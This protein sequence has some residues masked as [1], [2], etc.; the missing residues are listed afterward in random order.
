MICCK[1]AISLLSIGFFSLPLLASDSSEKGIH[2][3]V[4]FDEVRPIKGDVY[5]NLFDQHQGFPGDADRAIKTLKVAVTSSIL[6]CDFGPIPPG[7]YAVAAMHDENTNGKLDTNILGI[8]TEGW[9]VSNDVGPRLFGPPSFEAAS[10]E[11]NS[12]KQTLKIH[13]NFRY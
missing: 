9:A 10:I 6:S 3:T 11:L 13:M 2:L 1:A 8:P 7:V 12:S 4:K 5:C